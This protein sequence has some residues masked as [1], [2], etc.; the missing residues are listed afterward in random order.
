MMRER[1]Y[2][3]REKE[4]QEEERG[5]K[6]RC[7]HTLQQKLSSACHLSLF[8]GVPISYLE[9]TLEI[10]VLKV[11]RNVQRVL[12]ASVKIQISLLGLLS[13]S[14][15]KIKSNDFLFHSFKVI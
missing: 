15:N 2:E 7:Q 12:S 3:E 6:E 13:R 9:E 4:R 10:S 11:E 1:V 5:K 8:E 14:Q